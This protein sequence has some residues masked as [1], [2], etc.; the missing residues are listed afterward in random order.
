MP[1]VS[2]T[3]VLKAM[4][5]KVTKEEHILIHE[6]AKF[7]DSNF[8]IHRSDK[9]RAVK[10]ILAN[11]IRNS[12]YYTDEKELMRVYGKMRVVYKYML[13]ESKAEKESL[14]QKADN[15]KDLYS[16]LREVINIQSL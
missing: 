13:A 1:D 5:D 9:G 14:A 16:W 10:E 4:G 2:Y 11:C 3:K 7:C 15:K 8:K 12:K 6:I